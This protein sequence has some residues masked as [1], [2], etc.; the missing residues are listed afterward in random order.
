MARSAFVRVVAEHRPKFA[1]LNL[2]WWDGDDMTAGRVAQLGQPLYVTKDAVEFESRLVRAA[3]RAASK[4][5][6]KQ[7]TPKLRTRWPLR[8]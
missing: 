8:R 4:L 7:E 2:L 1:E 6:T 3:P 5:G